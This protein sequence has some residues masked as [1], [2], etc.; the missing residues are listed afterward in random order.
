MCVVKKDRKKELHWG[1]SSEG[2]NAL[3]VVRCADCSYTFWKNE[4]SGLASCED[5]EG[6]SDKSSP[7]PSRGVGAS[8]PQLQAKKRAKKLF[9][10]IY[11]NNIN[12]KKSQIKSDTCYYPYICLQWFLVEPQLPQ[13]WIIQIGKTFFPYRYILY[14]S[15]GL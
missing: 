14:I 8:A 9:F 10:Y 4:T 3:L 15:K 12:N 7:S 11:H 1:S 6:S 2:L 5:S 13:G